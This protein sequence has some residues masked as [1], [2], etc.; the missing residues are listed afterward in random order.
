M[1]QNRSA[2]KLLPV[3]LCL[4]GFPFG[5]ALQNLVAMLCSI[6]LVITVA[7]RRDVCAIKHGIYKLR[8]PVLAS[9]GFVGWI[10]IATYLNP[11][12]P[13]SGF[14]HNPCGYFFWILAPLLFYLNYRQGLSEIEWFRA[15]RILAIV[16]FLWGVCSV[17]QALWGWRI[18]GN[19]FIFEP[20]FRPRGF[21]SHPLTLAYAAFILWPLAINWLFRS[22]NRYWAWLFAIGVLA[23]VWFT[24]SRTIQAAA[25]LI[26]AWNGFFSLK[27]QMRR[28]VLALGVTFIASIVLV[29]NQCTQKFVNTFS[30]IGVDKHSNYPDDRLAF[31]HVHWNMVKERPVL[32]HGFTLDTA[33]RLPYYK[34]VG[35][36]DF[37]KPYEAHNMFL[38][39]LANGGL[40]GLS[41]FLI[42]Y[43]WFLWFALKQQDPL[44]RKIGWQTLI[45]F[46]LVGLTQNAFQDSSVR[47]VLTLFCAGFLLASFSPNLS[48]TSPHS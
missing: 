47:M 9:I 10:C 25:F 8:W 19:Q 46:A 29:P 30:Q 1:G 6:F 15:S 3:Y 5:I 38:Q 21:Y 7:S 48:K 18:L 26:F 35:L 2:W 33:Y 40:L 24:R 17:S 43:F 27:G 22:I 31:W 45:G 34:K 13:L 44:L 41:G 32:G 14:Y 4:L 42:W 39:I 36:D 12:N 16:G 37:S 23:S 20:H 28:V 11:K